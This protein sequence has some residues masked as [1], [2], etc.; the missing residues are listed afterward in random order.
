MDRR[1]YV[2]LRDLPIIALCYA[3]VWVPIALAIVSPYL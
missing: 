1:P 2:T 3:V